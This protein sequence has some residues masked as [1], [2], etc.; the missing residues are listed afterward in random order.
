VISGPGYAFDAPRIR[1]RA[2]RSFDRCHHP[3]GVERQLVA[4]AAS[5][6]RREALR[7]VAV[8]TLV[9]HGEDDP[10][11]P[12]ACG[13]DTLAAV[14]DAEGLFLP[15][16]GHDLP[17]ELYDTLADAIAATVRRAG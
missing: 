8:P 12:A 7:G 3:P 5:P 4:I 17:V 9:V 14:P 16:M 2:E 15:G 10:L 13:R 6:S 1:E 11:V